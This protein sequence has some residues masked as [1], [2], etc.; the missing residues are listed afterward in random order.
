MKIHPKYKKS[1]IVG[2]KLASRPESAEQYSFKT[3]GEAMDFMKEMETDGYISA[4]AFGALVTFTDTVFVCG[5]QIK[6]E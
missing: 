5:P 4:M 2:L 6:G 3:E 1:W